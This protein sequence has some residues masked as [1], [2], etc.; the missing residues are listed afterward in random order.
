ML[1]MEE[2]SNPPS[3]A[4]WIFSGTGDGNVLA[5]QIISLGY[6]VVL[7][8]ATEHGREMA[9]RSCPDA[10]VLFGRK[11]SDNRAEDLTMT[12]AKAIIDATH[13]YAINMS[14]QLI[15]LAEKLSLP[16]IRYERPMGFDSSD[17]KQDNVY[18]CDTMEAAATL[19]IAKGK[20]I[21]LGTGSKDLPTFLNAPG[22][23]QREWFVRITPVP[24]MITRALS[25]GVSINHICAMQGPFSQA[26]NEVLWRD[27][28][29][30]CVVTK[31]SG[32]AGGFTAKAQ[33]AKNLNIPLII[34]KRPQIRYPFVSSDFS[35][36]IAKLRVT[37]SV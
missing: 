4:I 25:L 2:N 30:D 23:D 18:A 22:S 21:F 10:F 12:H 14:E 1:D 34:V 35:A 31:D 13:P 26:F 5:N 16:Y 15:E 24:D 37:I 3:N 7:S 11:G 8:V 29:I 19:A 36:V 9:T 32:D 20:K 27:W 28:Q 33:A 17:E 6:A